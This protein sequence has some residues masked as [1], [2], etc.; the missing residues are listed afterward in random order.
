M[1]ILNYYSHIPL[2]RIPEKSHALG[3]GQLWQ[4]PFDGWNAQTAGAFEDHKNSYEKTAPVFFFMEIPVDWP[5]VVPGTSPTGKQLEV[6]LSTVLLNDPS[7]E[8]GFEFMTAFLRK[9]AWTAQAALTLAC[10]SA[11]PGSP[12][13]SMTICVPDDHFFNISGTEAILAR[14]Q[15]DADHEWLMLPEASSE[16]ISPRLLEFASQIWQFVQTA[17]ENHELIG[18]LNLLLQCA[19]PTLA[20]EDQMVIAT[21]ALEALL[22]PEIR[23]GLKAAFI[24]RLSALLSGSMNTSDLE[25]LAG[26]LYDARSSALHRSVPKE[27]SAVKKSVKNCCAQQLLA[28]CILTAGPSLISGSSLGELREE[29]DRGRVPN[30]AIYPPLVVCETPSSL[31]RTNRISRELPSSA[32]YSLV[33]GGVMHANEGQTVSWSPLMGLACDEMLPVQEGNFSIVSLNAVEL[34]EL[35]ERDI[36][37]D[38]IGQ[39]RSYESLGIQNFPHIACIGLFAQGSHNLAELTRRRQLS[40]AAL[41]L[42]G[43]STFT[44]PALLG[45]YIYEGRICFRIPTVYRQTILRQIAEEPV[46]QIALSDLKRVKQTAALLAD[47]H[48]SHVCDQ[49]DGLLGDFLRAHPNSFLPQKT[50]AVLLLGIMEAVLGRFRHPNSSIQLEDLVSCFAAAPD[51]QW[52]KTD[53]KSFRNAVAHGR[54]DSESGK[55]GIDVLTGIVRNMILAVIGFWITKA[56]TAQLPFKAF[57]KDLTVRLS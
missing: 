13:S 25:H 6:K 45:W 44:D 31:R 22:L 12:S 49:I 8:T 9:F 1:P 55:Q 19:E 42:A 21:I 15:G 24:R 3:P 50:T 57:L 14:I 33:A 35:E 46:Q 54:W 18:P 56:D 5:F 37:R 43:F 27:L 10:P 40:V 32:P 2:I 52:F 36:K 51:A 11:A 20:P 4:L 23:T 30:T 53:G 39:L 16:P 29:L 41:R 26:M 7:H 17:G 38:F 47:Y 48:K 28:A 34:V